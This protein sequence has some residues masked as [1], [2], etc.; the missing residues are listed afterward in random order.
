MP[1]HLAVPFQWT[2]P[3]TW[4][5]VFYFWLAAAALGFWR[6]VWRW[7]RRQQASNWP[8]VQGRVD[9]VQVDEPKWYAQSSRSGNFA[10]T[11]SYSYSA[12]G[13]TCTG[14][15]SRKFPGAA[16]AREFV[17]DTVGGAIAIHYNPTKPS[18][19]MAAESS[20]ETLLQTRP[21]NPAG[22]ALSPLNAISPALVP[23]VWVFVVLSAVGLGVSLF[24]HLGALMGRRVAPDSFFFLLHA[25]IFV[26]FVP[27]ILVAKKRVGTTRR[28]DFWKLVLRGSPEWVRYMF[29]G[30]FGYAFINFA[31][32]MFKAP[33]KGI[34]GNPP[35]TVWRGFSGHWMAFY[36]ASFAILYSAVS[37][38]ASGARC[39]NGHTLPPGASFCNQCGQPALRNS[40]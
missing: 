5:A 38:D 12:G 16:E 8:V 17:R 28:P 40:G 3:G 32:F 23:L 18:D 10:G 1:L 7:W 2:Q 33:T 9:A 35:D 22:A 31:L 24:V 20:I 39:I 11:L 37:P 15:Y 36:A 26:V 27:A 21:P 6:P 29:Y 19:S 34:A 14:K 30:F 25:G 13:Q 4:P